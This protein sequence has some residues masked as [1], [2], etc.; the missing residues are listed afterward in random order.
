MS[1]H[2]SS[3]CIVIIASEAN[4]FT[5]IWFVEI[6]IISTIL[7]MIINWDLYETNIEREE[8]HSTNSL[9]L[10]RFVS[11]MKCEMTYI[12]PVFDIQVLYN[13]TLQRFND[14][15]GSLTLRWW[16]NERGY[17]FPNSMIW[18]ISQFLTQPV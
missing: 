16:N 2:I 7:I 6:I 4:W 3:Q 1:T 13:V 5:L 14:E 9:T 18:W 17:R 10:W 11:E 15:V 8:C 12:F